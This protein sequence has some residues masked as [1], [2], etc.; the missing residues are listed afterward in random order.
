MIGMQVFRENF[1]RGASRFGFRSLPSVSGQSRKYAVYHM[2]VLEC[3]RASTCICSA[4][5]I[6][7]P[8]TK[9]TNC[10]ATTPAIMAMAMS[11]LSLQMVRVGGFYQFG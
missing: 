3:S 9:V 8:I 7:T 4:H 2:P 5:R 10:S 6:Y 1:K 11:Q